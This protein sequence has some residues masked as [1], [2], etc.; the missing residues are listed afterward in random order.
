M[1][2]M[3]TCVVALLVQAALGAMPEISQ[4]GPWGACWEVLAYSMLYALEVPAVSAITGG[5]LRDYIWRQLLLA[6]A[7]VVVYGRNLRNT[8]LSS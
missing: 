8:R 5:H 6:V 4:V 1:A 2:V 3:W 7:R